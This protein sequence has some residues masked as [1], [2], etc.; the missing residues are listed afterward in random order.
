MRSH[1]RFAA[2]A[3]AIFTAFFVALVMLGCGKPD[4]PAPSPVDEVQWRNDGSLTFQRDV[5]GKRE[6][7]TTITIEIA[8]TDTLRTRGLMGRSTIP[9]DRGMLFI[10][11]FPDMQGFW[12]ANT[13]SSLDL[14]FVS[15][16]SVI[17]DI[18][19]YAKPM[20]PE[21][22]AGREPAQFVVEVTAGYADT[23]GIVIGDRVTWERN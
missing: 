17:N 11:P 2:S 4:Q 23:Q 5:D 19:K 1:P 3:A 16:D 8:D 9:S 21:T 13:Q 15:E 10:F 14:M 22:V 18:A 20:S 6:D 12:M 7:I